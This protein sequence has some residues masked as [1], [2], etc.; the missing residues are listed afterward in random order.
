M[1]GQRFDLFG[2]PIDPRRGLTG[3]PR[4]M[5]TEA[6]RR[7]VRA[8]RQAGLSHDAIAAQIGI[9]GPTLRLNYPDELGSSSQV[10]KRRR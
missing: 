7:Q 6:L 5:P 3:R 4:H 9:T 10:W 2:E 1:T 8:L